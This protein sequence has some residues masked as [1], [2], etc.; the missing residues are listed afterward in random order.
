MTKAQEARWKAELEII[1]EL[2]RVPSSR[3]MQ[4]LLKE[5]KGIVVNHNTVNADLKRDLQAL[6]K[7]EYEKHKAGILGMLDAEIEIA[8]NIATTDPDNGVK[9]KAM[10]AVSKLS[11]TKADIINKFRRAQAEISHAERP[12]Y[13]VYIGQPKVAKEDEM[14][15]EDNKEDSSISSSD[16]EDG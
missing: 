2:G 16:E 13:K 12:I 11:K 14:N 15:D 8:H 10:S 9:L 3:E 7:E 6:T 4:K 1:Q 5:K